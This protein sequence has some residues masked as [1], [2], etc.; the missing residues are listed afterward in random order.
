MK[1]LWDDWIGTGQLLLL[2]YLG[3]SHCLRAFRRRFWASAAL[4]CIGGKLFFLEVLNNSR[5]MDVIMC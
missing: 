4:D 3:F 1:D 5:G 2:L